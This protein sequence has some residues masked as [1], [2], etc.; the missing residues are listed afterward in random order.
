M[1]FNSQKSPG[2]KP[3]PGDLPFLDGLREICYIYSEIA[4]PGPV[5]RE[6][7]EKEAFSMEFRIVNGTLARYLGR[8]GIVTIPDGV[9]QIGP[10]AFMGAKA[11]FPSASR[12]G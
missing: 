5:P 1:F 3:L 7:E 11:S 10:R 8:G 12:K 2:R 4:R 6:A 9:R